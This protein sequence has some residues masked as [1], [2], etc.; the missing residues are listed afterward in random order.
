MCISC[1]GKNF[2]LAFEANI[3][4]M[5]GVFA[6]ANQWALN[7]QVLD[8]LKYFIKINLLIPLQEE[9]IQL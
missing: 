3:W 7:N 4:N 2:G 8:L 9:K 5:S 6:D 1:C